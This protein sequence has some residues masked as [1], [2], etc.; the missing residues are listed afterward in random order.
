M[1]ID[2]SLYKNN[3]KRITTKMNDFDKYQYGKEALIELTGFFNNDDQ[4]APGRNSMNT[5]CKLETKRFEYRDIRIKRS[6]DSCITIYFLSPIRDWKIKRS[7][8]I[9]IKN[10]KRRDHLIMPE[11]FDSREDCEKWLHET[12]Y[13]KM[14]HKGISGLDKITSS[15]M[16]SFRDCYLR[17]PTKNAFVRLLKSHYTI[18]ESFVF[19]NELRISNINNFK[20]TKNQLKIIYKKSGTY[21]SRHFELKI[22]KPTRDNFI[23][24]SSIGGEESGYYCHSEG[25]IISKDQ[26][27]D[28]KR[29][30]NRIKKAV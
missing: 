22:K 29:F 12:F 2:K 25:L 26:L 6:W 7:I 30:I 14:G 13:S 16:Y 18:G 5:L 8:Y 19:N 11:R 17:N 10:S 15:L 28:A 9:E 3:L 20:E 21:E 23:R 4:C 27:D 24:L 1:S